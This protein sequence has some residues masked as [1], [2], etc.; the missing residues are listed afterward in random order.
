[1]TDR[2]LRRGM[3]GPDF[4]VVV[5]V[6]LVVVALGLSSAESVAD[7]PEAWNTRFE[8]DFGVKVDRPSNGVLQDVHWSEALFGYFPTYALGNLYAAQIFA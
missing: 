1:M 5:A 8:R 7:L 2:R 3:S 4:L 6:L